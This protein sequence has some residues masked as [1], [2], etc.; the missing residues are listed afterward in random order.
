MTRGSVLMRLLR[1]TMRP[2][3]KVMAMEIPSFIKR[4][5]S[6]HLLGAKHHAE[7]WGCIARGETD[8]VPA[9]RELTV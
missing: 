4:T 3:M 5:P 7:H 6:E 8:K 2:W 1:K 9:L